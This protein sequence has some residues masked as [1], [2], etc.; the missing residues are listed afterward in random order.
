MSADARISRR[1]VAP[2]LFCFFA[3]GASEGEALPCLAASAGGRPPHSTRHRGER[4]SRST[5][6]DAADP[7][8]PRR[9]ASLLRSWARRAARLARDMQD[10]SPISA[11]NE[12]VASFQSERCVSERWRAWSDA[13][14]GGTST[15]SVAFVETGAPHAGGDA[16]DASRETDRNERRNGALFL[17]G[18]LSTK[19][20]APLRDARADSDEC[21][22][23]NVT[24]PDPSEL[25]PESLLTEEETSRSGYESRLAAIAARAARARRRADRAEWRGREGSLRVAREQPRGFEVR[26]GGVRFA[27]GGGVT[28]TEA[29]RVAPRGALAA[30]EDAVRY[31]GGGA[32]RGRG[33]RVGVGIR[34]GEGM[35]ERGGTTSRGCVLSKVTKL[36]ARH[37]T[38]SPSRTSRALLT[39]KI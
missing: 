22:A 12:T 1:R 15:S 5:G 25:D 20:T 27:R 7:E 26:G 36:Y 19:T 3:L 13:P 33:G 16:R 11:S 17:R 29:S 8:S 9:M 34:G 32:S 24:P 35:D 31:L 28:A 30:G 23:T 18:A 10:V 39:A 2:K 38:R 4:A 6:R 21:I 37:A 14:H